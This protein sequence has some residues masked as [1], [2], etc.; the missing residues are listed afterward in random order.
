MRDAF[1]NRHPI[2]NFIFYIAA[3]GMG[4]CF[5]HPLFLCVSLLLSITYYHILKRNTLKYFIGMG[6]LFLLLSFANPIFSPYGDTVLF[7]YFHNRIYS[8]EALCF[9]FSI[10]AMFV[11]MIVWFSTYNEV[12]TSDKFL[13]CFGRLAPAVSMILTMMLRLIPNFWRKTEQIAG[14]RRCIGKSVE[15]G[16]LYE[17][18]EHGMTIISTL[19]SWALEGG[20][21]MADSMRSRGFGCGKRTSFSI[22][23]LKKSDKCLITVMIVQIFIIIL[24]AVK[25]GMEAVYLPTMHIQGFNNIWTILGGIAYLMLL[26]IP[27]FLHIWEAIIWRILKSKI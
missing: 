6:G 13:Y 8:Y 24:C 1:S 15:N 9:G 17:K 26:S 21:I 16:S 5:T 14:A 25:G 7:I 19:T 10:A 2:V 18:I 12:M 27:T 20:V 22:Y 4:M 3:I 11:S 23:K